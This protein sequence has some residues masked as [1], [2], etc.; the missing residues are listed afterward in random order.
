MTDS[1]AAVIAPARSPAGARAPR[2]STPRGETIEVSP[3]MYVGTVETA[4]RDALPAT[5]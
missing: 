3:R 5:G 1:P 2:V 4:D